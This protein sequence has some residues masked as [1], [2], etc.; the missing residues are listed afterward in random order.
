MGIIV[1]DGADCWR[2]KTFAPNIATLYAVI[3]ASLH[4]VPWAR[5]TGA[6]AVSAPR[7]PDQ[8]RTTA[9]TEPAF[10]STRPGPDRHLGRDRVLALDD[11]DREF[12]RRLGQRVADHR[13]ARGMTQGELAS[14]AG[15]TR[16]H[17][18][19]VEKGRHNVTVVLLRRL[20]DAVGVP[21]A[22]LVDAPG[23]THWQ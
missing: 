4:P 9:L 7:A 12:L 1:W 8:E 2:S 6:T 11:A 21:V 20:A 15:I 14:A 3:S 23:S 22:A 18:C 5:R 16:G 10:R 19:L 13:T 17:V